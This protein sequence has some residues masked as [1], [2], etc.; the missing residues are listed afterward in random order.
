MAK[1]AKKVSSPILASCQYLVYSEFVLFK[2][3]NFYHVNAASTIDTFYKLRTDFDKLTNVFELTKI[4]MTVISEHIETIEILTLFLNTL[5]VYQGTDKLYIT[6]IFKVRLLKL[7]GFAP[8]IIKCNLCLCNLKE[9][10]KDVSY[11]YAHNFFIC[12]DCIKDNKNVYYDVRYKTY[13][14]I[15]YI[16]YAKESN[17]FGIKLDKISERQLKNFSDNYTSCILNNL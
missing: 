16:M 5:F 7:L 14:N 11:N 17:I 2:G 8:D 1:S 3:T 9:S 15:V 10:K 4:L 12:S 6:D 13:M